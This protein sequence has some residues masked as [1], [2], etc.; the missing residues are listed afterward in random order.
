MRSSRFRQRTLSE[1]SNVSESVGEAA[2]VDSC[3][4]TK[5][6]SVICRLDNWVAEKWGHRTTTV[7]SSVSVA[8]STVLIVSFE[9]TVICKFCLQSAV[10]GKEDR[11]DYVRCHHPFLRRLR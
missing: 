10:W 8:N 9:L 1:Y 7:E 3:D 11:S 4:S 5:C 2:R 6:M